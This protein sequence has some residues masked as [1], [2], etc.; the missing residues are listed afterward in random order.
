MRSRPFWA[1]SCGGFLLGCLVGA[2]ALSRGILAAQ[3]APKPM[4][5]GKLPGE[6]T[7]AD[8]LPPSATMPTVAAS[9][10]QRI[11]ERISQAK[12]QRRETGN[13]RG[14]VRNQPG[15]GT[16]LIVPSR[17]CQGAC[18]TGPQRLG[19]ARIQRPRVLHRAASWRKARMRTTSHPPT[20]AIISCPRSR[21]SRQSCGEALLRNRLAAHSQ[22][23]AGF[24]NIGQ[25]FAHVADAGRLKDRLH[26]RAQVFVQQSNQLEQRRRATV[27][28]VEHLA[29]DILGIGR[30]QIALHHVADK[31]EVA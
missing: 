11:D 4:A 1:G 31:G 20:V 16:M 28:N 29:A 24:A 14:Y 12:R 30:Q 5:A 10:G 18:A 23:P 17:G 27:G 6:A 15:V 25:A 19:P 21:D 9:D 13:A 3:M 8:A 22:R 2:W 26:F 7:P